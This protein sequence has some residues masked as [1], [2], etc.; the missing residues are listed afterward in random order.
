MQNSWMVHG[1]KGNAKRTQH[2]LGVIPSSRHSND[3]H[4]YMKHRGAFSPKYPT[5][6]HCMFF[7]TANNDIEFFELILRG[8]TWC[9]QLAPE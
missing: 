6:I 9:V 2:T 1:C 5:F 4:D 8:G 3:E 7:R